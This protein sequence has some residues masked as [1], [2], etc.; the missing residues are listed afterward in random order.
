MFNFC[1]RVNSNNKNFGRV[2]PFW[3][4]SK[5]LQKKKE[6]SG[7]DDD[8]FEGTESFLFIHK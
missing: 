3:Q 5:W 6:I 1:V 8:V 4:N 2:E 7:S